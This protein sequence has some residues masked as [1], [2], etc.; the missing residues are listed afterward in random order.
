MR[1]KIYQ[2]VHIYEG[3]IFSIAYKYMMITVIAASLLPLTVKEDPAYFTTL[4]YTCLVVFL[5]D[6]FLRW[7]SADYKFE[8]HSWKAFFKYPFRII[9]MIDLLSVFALASSVGRWF[10]ETNLTPVLA[11]FR[12]IRILRYSKSVRTIL[13]I[14][15][16]SK[17]PLTAVGGLAVG[18]ILISAIVIINVE[19]KSFRTFFDAVYWSTV[20]LTT[21][22]YGDIYPVTILGRTVAMVSSFFGIAIVAL[23]AGIVTAE[24][25]GAIKES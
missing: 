25:L 22:G 4:E 10:L 3:N 12:I 13:V 24:Y 17:K 5:I 16:K 9:S 6:Y 20:S 19:P 23:S 8:D 2:I 7:V 18:Y 21:V 15:R 1:K 11:V 14:L